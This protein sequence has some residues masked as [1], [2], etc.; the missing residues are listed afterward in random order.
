M[1]WILVLPLL[2]TILIS[3]VL[4]WKVHT[5]SAMPHLSTAFIAVLVIIAAWSFFEILFIHASTLGDKTLVDAFSY[6]PITLLPV[7][8]FHFASLYSGRGS[9]IGSRR[10]YL[11]FI[12]PFATIALAFTN[13]AHG[14]IWKEMS[15]TLT[16]TGADVQR[17]YGTW[18]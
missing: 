1:E 12:I 17:T 3:S 4:V 2:L 7:A 13:G 5:G 14:L 18:F 6:I 9:I 15:M 8:L 11:L 10:S 16:E